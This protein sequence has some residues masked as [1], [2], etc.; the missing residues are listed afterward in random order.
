MG[1]TRNR[2]A[3]HSVPSRDR[4][5]FHAR[6]PVL[7][8]G[9]GCALVWSKYSTY[10]F[11]LGRFRI[12]RSLRTNAGLC[13]QHCEHTPPTK[14]FFEDPI[15]FTDIVKRELPLLIHPAGHGDQREPEWVENSLRLQ[16]P[17]SP[18]RGTGR[19]IANSGGSSI[20]TIRDMG[21]ARTGNRANTRSSEVFPIPDSRAVHAPERG[22]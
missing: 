4:S 6:A 17:L 12:E 18:A 21:R 11:F 2:W 20:R 15:L 22:R 3:Q 8:G 7:D 1:E 13:W 19:I 5:R 14:L 10:R 16:C 9:P